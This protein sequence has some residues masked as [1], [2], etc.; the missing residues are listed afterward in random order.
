MWDIFASAAG[1]KKIAVQQNPFSQKSWIGVNSSQ[2][3][4]LNHQQK[5]IFDGLHDTRL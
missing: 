2:V 5:C 4:C 3:T 1:Y